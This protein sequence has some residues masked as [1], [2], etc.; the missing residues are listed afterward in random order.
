MSDRKPKTPAGLGAAGKA[1]WRRLTG[2]FDFESGELVIL[3]TAARQADALAALEAV[4]AESGLMVAGSAGQ[5]RLNPAVAEC[6]QG[7]IALARMLGMLGM[8]DDEDKPMTAASRSA[9]HASEARWN[10]KRQEQER[11]AQR[12]DDGSA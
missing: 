9:R 6:R 4:V 11:R 2:T 3:E 7:R 1:L 10:R 8:P 5:P 12:L